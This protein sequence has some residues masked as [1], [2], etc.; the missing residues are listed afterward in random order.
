MKTDIWFSLVKYLPPHIY[1]VYFGWIYH[2]T[3]VKRISV[4][5]QLNGNNLTKWA[6]NFTT[7][8]LKFKQQFATIIMN[9]MLHFD[10]IQL[11]GLTNKV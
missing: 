10:G 7:V 5:L 1:T 9:Y 6:A 11:F 2:I 8:W 4:A 3:N